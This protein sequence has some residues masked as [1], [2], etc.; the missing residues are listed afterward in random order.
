MIGV[1]GLGVTA[2][3]PESQAGLVEL[4]DSG[5]NSLLSSQLPFFFD[6]ISSMR[7]LACLACLF[8][9]VVSSGC[10]PQNVPPPPTAKVTGKVTLDG[11]AMAEG[12][13]HFSVMGQ[14]PKICPIKDGAFSGEVFVG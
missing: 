5:S 2:S 14:P 6:G 11:K 13:V 10:T 3:E 4:C 1:G 8:L 12:E 7:G 9:L